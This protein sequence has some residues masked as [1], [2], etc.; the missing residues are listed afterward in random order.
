MCVA[1]KVSSICLWLMASSVV[2]AGN[3]IIAG[4]ESEGVTVERLSD[5]RLG[6]MK[7]ASMIVG[8]AHPSV[9]SGLKVHQITWNKFGSLQD[10]RSYWYMGSDYDP[11]RQY[12]VTYNGVDYSV[13]GDRWLADTISGPGSWRLANATEIEYHYQALNK[14]TAAPEN[15]GFRASSW[16]R[17][18]STFRW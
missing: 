12:G 11:H 16:N 18:I 1:F 14:D 2:F 5:E 13:G 9:I 10:H 3:P 8:Q 15:F 6:Q 17:P 7:G 4:L